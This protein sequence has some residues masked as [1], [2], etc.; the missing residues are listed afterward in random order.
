M[1]FKSKGSPSQLGDSL[2]LLQGDDGPVEVP[3]VPD[4]DVVV[5][6]RRQ[7]VVEPRIDADAVNGSREVARR[8]LPAERIRNSLN[9]FI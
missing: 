4:D 9:I 7:A 3:R 5:V 1:G 2:G 6:V 8:R